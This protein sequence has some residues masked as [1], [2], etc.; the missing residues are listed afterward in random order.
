MIA[1]VWNACRTTI[2]RGAWA[3]GQQLS[4][5]GWIYSLE[6]GLLV[7]LEICVS[8]F[9]ELEPRFYAAIDRLR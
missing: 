5:Q 8:R 6:D 9:E 3:R 7:D 4:V 1:Q 2:V